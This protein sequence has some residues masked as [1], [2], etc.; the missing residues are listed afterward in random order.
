MGFGFELVAIKLP[1]Y[2]WFESEDKNAE[3]SF[4]GLLHR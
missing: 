1:K 3:D 2:L 4:S